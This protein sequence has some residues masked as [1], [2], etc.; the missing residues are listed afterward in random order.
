MLVVGTVARI[1]RE[2][3]VKGKSFKEIGRDLKEQVDNQVGLVR[4]RFITCNGSAEMLARQVYKRG[5]DLH[6]WL[7]Q[8]LPTRQRPSGGP[9]RQAHALDCRGLRTPL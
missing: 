5:I 2:F 8:P 6:A 4:E 3:F 7:T 9:H 1:R